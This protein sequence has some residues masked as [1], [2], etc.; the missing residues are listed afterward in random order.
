MVGFVVTLLCVSW[1]I[2]KV[3]YDTFIAQVAERS[4]ATDCKSVA[5]WAT[6]VQIPPCAQNKVMI[7]LKKGFTSLINWLSETKEHDEAIKDIVCYDNKKTERLIFLNK[8]IGLPINKTHILNTDLF[9]KDS[10]FI[11]RVI[12]E[13]GGN[14]IKHAFRVSPKEEY[15]G[16]FEIQKL[17]GLTFKEFW[18]KLKLLPIPKDKAEVRITNFRG[19]PLAYSAIIVVSKDG[20]IGEIVEGDLYIITYTDEPKDGAKV[21]QFYKLPNEEVVVLSDSKKVKEKVLEI[22]SAISVNSKLDELI[23]GGFQ[24]YNGYVAGYYEYVEGK[25][26][27]RAFT[28]MN[29]KKISNNISV[30]ETVNNI[31]K[32]AE[33]NSLQGLVAYGTDLKIIGKVVLLKD[34]LK[35]IEANSIL[36]CSMTTVNQLPLMKKASAVIT[37]F[38][39]LM[40][41]PAIISREL[42]IPTIV[43]TKV[44]TQIL[45]DG[46]LIEVDSKKGIVKIK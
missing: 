46:D 21:I 45:K 11:D 27:D 32:S 39:G 44:A 5:L 25:N 24:I 40:S 9:E 7:E 30:K 23:T 3:C 13:R 35:D 26:G 31:R 34:D 36:V 17:Y 22:I 43:G 1:K 19:A 15:V 42:K 38:G 28:D 6:G 10:V 2:L 8:T 33:E 20:I 37:D 12:I 4:I 41:H 16:L 14:D 18:E 29:T